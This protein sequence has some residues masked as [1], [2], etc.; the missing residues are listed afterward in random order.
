LDLNLFIVINIQMSSD[1]YSILG[2]SKKANQ[3]E[4]K[5]AFHK[6]SLKFH[7]D[8]YKGKSPEKNVQERYQNIVKAYEILG[9]SEKRNSYNLYGDKAEQFG[10]HQQHGGNPFGGG[11]QDMFEKMFNQQ[12]RGG[13]GGSAP[14]KED[15]TISVEVKLSFAEAYTGITKTASIKRKTLCKECSGRGTPSTEYIDNCSKC[16]G[17]GVYMESRRIN[18][19]TI[20]QTQQTCNLCKGKGS[21]IRAGKE[22]TKCTAGCG[23][24]ETSEMTEIPIPKGVDT[25]FQLMF[26]GLGH[27][28]YS[29]PGDLVIITKVGDPPKDWHRNQNDIKIDYH[30]SLG[31][32]LF[33]FKKTLIHLDKRKIQL[34]HAGVMQSHTTK[35]I[36]NEGF[37]NIKSESSYGKL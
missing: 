32:A 20:Q 28:M 35:M 26:G 16:Q 9:D 6:L 15:Q 3:S 4:I 19:F 34:E 30:I 18:Q 12:Q 24:T 21:S 5:K 33:G 7:P 36:V 1:H 13:G 2:V 27:K 11:F 14:P 8:K 25:G 17:Q 22:C 23:Y 37:K 10:Q 29:K 31:D